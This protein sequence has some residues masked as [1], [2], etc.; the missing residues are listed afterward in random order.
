MRKLKSLSQEELSF[1]AKIARS[2][3]QNIES[4]KVD[5]HFST[6]YNLAKA[7]E[8]DVTEFFYDIAPSAFNP[9]N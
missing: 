9:Y 1:S 2:T 7:L 3:L 8:V 4:G 5:P 6:L